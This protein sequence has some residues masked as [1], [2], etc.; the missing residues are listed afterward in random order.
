MDADRLRV[1]VAV[2][3]AGSI[4][5]AAQRLSV[6]PSALS[7]QLSKL[8]RSVGVRL[9][10]RGPGGVRPTEAGVVLVRHGERVLGEL[11]DAEDAVRE[12]LGSTPERLALGTFASMGALLVPQVLAEFRR[13]HPGV[14]LA[15][16]DI[17]RPEGYGLV[18]SRELDV[19]ITHRYPGV[20]LPPL[21]GARRQRLLTDPL[22]LVLPAGHRLAR[23]PRI[24]LADLAG[25]EWISGGPGVPNRVCLTALAARDRLEL[26]VAFETRDYGVMLGLLRAGVGV[27]LVPA[28]VLVSTEGL[29]V[30]SVHG[31]TPAREVYVVHRRRPLRL[32]AEVVRLLTEAGT[33]MEAR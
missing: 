28:S 13:R 6:T 30:R 18:A 15:L 27:S 2:V 26:H 4:S 3:Q 7:Q 33:R 32:T 24:R 22:R 21:G 12:L 17:E 25:E 19:L 10:D 11:R 5:A 8:E 20:A 29:A 9:L 1:L 23:A 31:H 14:R 16:L